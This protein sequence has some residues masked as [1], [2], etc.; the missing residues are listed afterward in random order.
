MQ[1]IM[2]DPAFGPFTHDLLAARIL[3]QHGIGG[4]ACGA[5]LRLNHGA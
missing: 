2:G 3:V 1:A 5:M 4:A